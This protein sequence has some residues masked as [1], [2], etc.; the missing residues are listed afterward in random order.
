[1][2]KVFLTAALISLLPLSGAVAAEKGHDHSHGAAEKGKHGGIV[3]DVA[4]VEAELVVTPGTIAVYLSNHGAAPVSPDGAM[5]SVLLTQG[6][7]RLG[8]IALK[9]AGDRLEGQ[10]EVPADADIVLSL[11]TKE[12]KTGQAKF[13][14]SGHSH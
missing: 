12:G 5:A 13:E 7:Q 8:T 2:L 4:G 10:G 14:R 9:P 3:Q 11:R 6:T 1:M